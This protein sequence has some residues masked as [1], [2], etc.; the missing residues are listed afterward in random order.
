MSRKSS[1]LAAGIVARQAKYS[2][3]DHGMIEPLTRETQA[4]DNVFG[5]KIW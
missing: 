2:R 5:F 1:V 4:C 3:R